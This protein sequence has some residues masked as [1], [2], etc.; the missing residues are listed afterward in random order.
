M[1]L[2]CFQNIWH[3]ADGGLESYTLTEVWE[4]E[5]HGKNE[6]KTSLYSKPYV[7]VPTMGWLQSKAKSD[8]RARLRSSTRFQ[9]HIVSSNN[10][11][12][13][14]SALSFSPLFKTENH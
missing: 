14:N 4:R 3:R 12:R 8:L 5:S 6:I 2:N 10:K 11:Q 13:G 9:A 7:E 1:S